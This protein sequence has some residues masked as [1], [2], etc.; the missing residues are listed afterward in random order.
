MEG[1]GKITKGKKRC[2]KVSQPI[3]APFPL[4]RFSL[5]KKGRNFAHPL[6]FKVPGDER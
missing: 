3:S 1:Y 5:G 6:F 2:L 4:E